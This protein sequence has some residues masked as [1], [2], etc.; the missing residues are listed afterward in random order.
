MALF[1]GAMGIDDVAARDDPNV[2]QR[3]MVGITIGDRH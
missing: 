1:D 3:R 2:L